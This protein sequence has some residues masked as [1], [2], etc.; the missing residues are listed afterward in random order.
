LGDGEYRV[1]IA[2]ARALGEMGPE[3]NGAFPAIAA[4]LR[5]DI[6]DVR[7]EALAAMVVIRGK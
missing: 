3:A 2:A 7:I 4:L 5:D 6:A 1:R